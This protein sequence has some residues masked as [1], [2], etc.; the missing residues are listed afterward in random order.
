MKTAS[1]LV[2]LI[3]GGMAFAAVAAPPGLAGPPGTGVSTVVASWGDHAT[4]PSAPHQYGVPMCTCPPPV[5]PPPGCP[6]CPGE[7]AGTDAGTGD[8]GT[9]DAGTADAGPGPSDAGTADAGTVDSGTPGP[10]TDAGTAADGGATDTIRYAGDGCSC[11]ATPQAAL[12]FGLL[13][14]V[15]LASR[16]RPARR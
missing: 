14:L 12:T 10:T 7:D 4:V 11:G 1:K 6:P 16:R 5:T 3:C 8:A 2:V 13:A 15:A 9:P